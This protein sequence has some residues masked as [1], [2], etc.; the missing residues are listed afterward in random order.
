VVIY[1]GRPASQCGEQPRSSLYKV[2]A[3]RKS[4]QAWAASAADHEV[5]AHPQKLS[6]DCSVLLHDLIVCIR[7]A[8]ACRQKLCRLRLLPSCVS[9]LR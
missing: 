8:C 4:L 5:L 2:N 9:G 7:F 6:V 3:S 1:L